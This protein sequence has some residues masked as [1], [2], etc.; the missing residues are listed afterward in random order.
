MER[1]SNSSRSDEGSTPSNAATAITMSTVDDEESPLLSMADM[2]KLL[3]EQVRTIDQA[4]KLIGKQF[5]GPQDTLTF[6]V[7]TAEAKLVLMCCHLEQLGRQYEDS[8]DYIEDMLKK[9][10]VAAIGK[11]VKSEDFYQFMRFQYQNK[12]CGEAHSPNPFCFA[13]RRPGYYPDGILSIEKM[14]PISAWPVTTGCCQQLR[15]CRDF[16]T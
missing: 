16:H 1:N 11:E 6:L 13:V 14:K 9:Q 4:T 3:G 12:L 5:P 15:A 10:L 8:V 2:D 7:S